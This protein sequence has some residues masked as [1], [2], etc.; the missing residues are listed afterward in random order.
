MKKFLPCLLGF[1]LVIILG[2]TPAEVEQAVEQGNAK[3]GRF[4]ALMDAGKTTREQEQAYI[5]SVSALALQLDAAIRGATAAN[6]TRAIV[7]PVK[8][9]PVIPV[10]EAH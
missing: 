2:C 4:E 5:H 10:G 6:A 1:G 9:A 7:Q 3:A 8:P